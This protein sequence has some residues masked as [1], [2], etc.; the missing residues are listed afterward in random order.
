MELY[1]LISF[2]QVIF[3]LGLAICF[4]CSTNFSF[5]I[6]A[7]LSQIADFTIYLWFFWITL[8]LN[9]KNSDHL[10]RVFTILVFSGDTS[11]L[12]RSSIHLVTASFVFTASSLVLQK[13]LKSSAYRM[14]CIS[15]NLVLRII[16]Y[17]LPLSRTGDVR[18][19]R[20]FAFCNARGFSSHWLAT[21]Q[22]S[23]FS[24]IFASKGEI[25]P[26]CGAPLSGIIVEPSCIRIGALRIRRITNSSCLSCIPIAHICFISL[27][28]FTLSK[29]PFMSNS[30]T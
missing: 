2:K 22:S 10:L 12:S 3:S 24:T 1:N 30:M 15:F 13:I 25:I 21:H 18:I 17:P 26:P 23:S 5:S 19:I 29:N 9:P 6:L 11:S 8:I 16:L 7:F 28:W 27:L 4:A 14:M 20:Y